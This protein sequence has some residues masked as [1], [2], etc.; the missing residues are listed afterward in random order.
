MVLL[1]KAASME[2][3]CGRVQQAVDKGGGFWLLGV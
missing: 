1:G 2:P 3:G